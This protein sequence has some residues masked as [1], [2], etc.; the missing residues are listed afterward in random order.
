M[1]EI[2]LS[3]ASHRDLM[4]LIERDPVPALAAWSAEAATFAA[5][6][7]PAHML[8]GLARYVILGVLPGAFLRAV[9]FNDLTGA[10]RRADPENLRALGSWGLWMAA[11]APEGS[12][13]SAAAMKEWNERGGLR[14]REEA[15]QC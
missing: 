13:G 2:N 4:L 8:P 9:I 7:L 12:V 15:T 6:A 14:G 5:E 10:A 1:T 11:A 3:T